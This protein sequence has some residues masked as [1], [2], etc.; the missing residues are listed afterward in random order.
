MKESIKYAI[1]ACVEQK[2]SC[3]QRYAETDDIKHK[4]G[5]EKFKYTEA[6]LRGIYDPNKE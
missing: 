1:Q 6:V 2:N 5:Y 3:A 4:Y